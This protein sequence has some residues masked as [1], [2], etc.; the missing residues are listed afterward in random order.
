MP[1]FLKRQELG[2]AFLG[3]LYFVLHGTLADVRDRAVLFF[4][5]VFKLLLQFGSNLEGDQLVTFHEND[6][7]V[8]TSYDKLI[9]GYRRL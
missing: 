8:M 6:Y 2:S 4:S 3:L 7:T 1:L 5:Q 9:K